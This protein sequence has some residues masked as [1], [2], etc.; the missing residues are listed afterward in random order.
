MADY[1]KILENYDYEG[2]LKHYGNEYLQNNCGGDELFHM[3]MFDEILEN[4]KPSEILEKVDKT[5]FDIFDS[6]FY[7]NVY[8]AICSTNDYIEYMEEHITQE[9]F[10]NWCLEHGYIE[11]EEEEQE[12]ENE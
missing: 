7:F 8:G 9:E 12:E 4:E 3:E 1:E 10:L 11:E 2:L 6:Y 5:C